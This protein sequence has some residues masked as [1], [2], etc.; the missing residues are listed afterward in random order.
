MKYQD[1]I[2][3]LKRC[4]SDNP[5]NYRD[6]FK[7]D[8]IYYLNEDFHTKNSLLLFLNDL[9][10]EKEIISFVDSLNSSILLKFDDEYE[11]IGD[12]IHEYILQRKLDY[13]IDKN[14]MS[15]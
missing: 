13:L 14:T 10:T 5:K 11:Q 1:K 8:I 4:L 9:N 15:L 2:N 7:I 12:F 3:T 6:N